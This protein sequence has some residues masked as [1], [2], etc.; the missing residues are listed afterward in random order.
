MSTSTYAADRPPLSGALTG[1]PWTLTAAAPAVLLP[2]RLETRFAGAT[3]KIR[4]YPD[5]IHVDDHE[6]GL[7]V[8]EAAA[9][10]TYWGDGQPGGPTGTPDEAAWNELVRRFGAPRAGWIARVLEPVGGVFPDP[11]PRTGPW[12]EPAR[13]RLLPT[14]WYAVGRTAGGKLFT[15]TSDPVTRDLAVGPSPVPDTAPGTIDP[16]DQALPIDAGMRWTVDFAAATAAGMAFTVTVPVT[17]TGEP[18]QIERL[19]VF[20]LDAATGPAD[21]ARALARLLEAH[22]ATDGL[23]F[24][25]PDTPTNNTGTDTPAATPT[26]AATTTVG[27]SPRRPAPGSS[28]RR[29]LTTVT[30]G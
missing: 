11:L 28:T 7:T 16:G 18:E 6:P 8:D 27:R 4:V 1:T 12:C 30:P 13:A 14:R 23:A 10:R 15:G 22:A 17:A 29:P 9:G 24:L 20:G 21:S 3:L 25:A 26:L 19:L 2:V 5:Q